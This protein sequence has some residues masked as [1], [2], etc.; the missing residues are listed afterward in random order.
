MAKINHFLRPVKKQAMGL[1]KSALAGQLSSFL[2]SLLFPCLP[3]LGVH[4]WQQSPGRINSQFTIS[5]RII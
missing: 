1:G 2:L 3:D 4:E 5:I